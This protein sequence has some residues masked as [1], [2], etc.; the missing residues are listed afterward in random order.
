[1][2]AEC[3]MKD[4]AGGI[5]VR[6]AAGFSALASL[7]LKRAKENTVPHVAFD[8]A[9]LWSGWFGFSAGLAL[10]MGPIAVAAAMNSEIAA[11]VALFPWLI[12]AWV[13]LGR[14]GLVRL[15]VGVVAGLAIADGAECWVTSGAPGSVTRSGEQLGKQV[16]ATTCCA[17]YSFVVTYALLRLM[18]LVMPVRPKVLWIGTITARVR[19]TTH[20]R[21][22]TSRI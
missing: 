5:V 17:A 16:V 15:C 7:F 12:I 11:S 3:G 9:S 21:G 6:V 18:S 19:T 10:A 2:L 13:H 22:R 1:M 14:P 4:F 8:T 20:R